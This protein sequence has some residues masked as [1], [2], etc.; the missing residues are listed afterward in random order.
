MLTQDLINLKSLDDS[1]ENS[2]SVSELLIA[3]GDCV[4]LGEE[5]CYWSMGKTGFSHLQTSFE[6]L[7]AKLDWLQTLYLISSADGEVISI[8]VR[9]LF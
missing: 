5:K 4:P 9:Q 8:G 6:H 1:I 3:Y 7:P 2:V